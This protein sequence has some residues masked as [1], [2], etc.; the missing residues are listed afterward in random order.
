[1]VT[2]IVSQI[3]LAQ[4]QLSNQ[5]REVTTGET[6]SMIPVLAASLTMTKGQTIATNS[7]ASLPA[8]GSFRSCAAEGV[9]AALVIK[10]QLPPLSRKSEDFLDIVL[11]IIAL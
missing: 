9:T 6:V 11:H 10:S 8:A 4:Q 5:T 1:M 7:C 2:Q 3:P